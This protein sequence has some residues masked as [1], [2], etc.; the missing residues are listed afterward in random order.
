MWLGS[1]RP[2]S[3]CVGGMLPV[4]WCYKHVLELPRELHTPLM[5]TVQPLTY[6]L[7]RAEACV[8]DLDAAK[9][10]VRI[11]TTVRDLDEVM[12]G[13]SRCELSERPNRRAGDM[14]RI[15]P[16]EAIDGLRD[17]IN[18]IRA[19]GEVE[20]KCAHTFGQNDGSV[21]A[22]GEYQ[23][24]HYAEDDYGHIS[25]TEESMPLGWRLFEPEREDLLRVLSAYQRAWGFYVNGIIRE[26]EMFRNH[27]MSS[28]DYFEPA[29]KHAER[30][31]TSDSES[32]AH[33]ATSE[34]RKKKAAAKAKQ[35]MENRAALAQVY[36]ALRNSHTRVYWWLKVGF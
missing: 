19:T 18:E 5:G 2:R 11:L 25:W 7:A 24:P 9:Q 22:P 14:T 17:S 13:L 23:C 34:D 36:Y 33:V 10:M 30:A 35:D 15:S 29:V 31:M 12:K 26:G 16:Y 4:Q 27:G 32:W 3:Q 28:E 1:I 21:G 8:Q 20:D 6:L